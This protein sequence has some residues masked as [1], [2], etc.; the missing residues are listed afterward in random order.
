MMD[1]WMDTFQMWLGAVLLGTAAAS[2]YGDFW[3]G[4][5]VACAMIGVGYIVSSFRK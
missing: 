2:F 1:D 3:L 5:T 4:A